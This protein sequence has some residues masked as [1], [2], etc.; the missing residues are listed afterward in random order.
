MTSTNDTVANTVD[1]DLQVQRTGSEGEEMI[2]QMPVDL[3]Q[4]DQSGLQSQ[5][6]FEHDWKALARSSIENEVTDECSTM[7]RKQEWHPCR[8]GVMLQITFETLKTELLCS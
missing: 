2:S 3:S 5:H 7:L 4:L 8:P 1:L 6:D